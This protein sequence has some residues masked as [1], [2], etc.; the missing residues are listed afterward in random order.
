MQAETLIGVAVP[1]KPV[2]ASRGEL[3]RHLERIEVEAYAALLAAAPHP[4]ATAVGLS[5]VE[6]GGATLLVAPRIP[7]PLFNRAI[8]LG[9]DRPATPED[10]DEILAVYREAGV[11]EAWIHRCPDAG[12]AELPAWLAARGMSVARRPTWAKVAIDAARPPVLPPTRNPALTVREIGPSEASTFSRLVTRAHGMPEGMIPWTSAL[13]GAPSL[14]A[15]L[16]EER[17]EAVGA[18][19]LYQGEAGAWL[20]LGATAAEHR[21]KGVQGAVMSRRI[22]D[23]LEAG[24]RLVTTETGEP[25][26]TEGDSENPSLRN[27]YRHGFVRAYSRWNHATA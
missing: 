27:M 16:V 4:F 2:D 10:L 21:N 18:G 8:G 20:G 5:V 9:L 22:R 12:P 19:L 14:R 13:V 17:G 11:A 24:A 26:A 25:I 15:Y 23:A 7:V 6:A 1:E 3:T